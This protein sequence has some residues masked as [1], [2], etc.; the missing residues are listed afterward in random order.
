L[1]VLGLI[2]VLGTSGFYFFE[3]DFYAQFPVL[4]VALGLAMLLLP[5][6]SL[7][8]SSK[9]NYFGDSRL[10]EKF[11]Y[12]F[13]SE[14]IQVMG[15]SFHTTFA[16]DKLYKLEVSTNWVLLWQSAQMAL[17]IPKRDVG[18]QQIETLKRIAGKYPGV[19]KKWK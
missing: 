19:G 12:K 6:L 11:T 10:R 2:L 17:L 18:P 5:P 7:W 13:D 4:P 3:P 9:K 1:L 15:E 8:R 16:W 14:K